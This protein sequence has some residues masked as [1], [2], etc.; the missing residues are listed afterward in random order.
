M[1]VILKF[2]R[3][4]QKENILEEDNKKTLLSEGQPVAIWKS[5]L[6]DEIYE[7]KAWYIPDNLKI[8]D[9][10]FGALF[11]SPFFAYDDD[12]EAWNEILNFTI[13]CNTPQL[14]DYENKRVYAKD[15]RYFAE[16]LAVAKKNNH[17]LFDK[18]YEVLESNGLPKKFGKKLILN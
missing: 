1:Q 15:W 14:E 7:T 12:I 6:K 2:I 11:R 3:L 10:R 13:K 9:R 18:A 4:L 8:W 16:V 5:V 17:P